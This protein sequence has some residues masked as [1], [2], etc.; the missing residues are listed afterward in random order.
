M[1]NIKRIAKNTSVFFVSQIINYIICFFIIFYSARYLGVEG[2]GILSLALAFTGIFGIFATLGL[3]TLTTREVSRDKSQANHYIFNTLMIR[4]ILSILT[5]LMVFLTVKLFGYSQIVQ[6][7]ILIITISM[8]I[9]SFCEIFN[10]IFQA[11]EKVEYQVYGTILNSLIILIGILLIINYE[12]GIYEIAYTYL[13][14]S[15]FLLL[16]TLLIFSWKF[17]IPKIDLDLNFWKPTIKEALPFGITGITGMIYT[18]TDSL[19]LSLMQGTEVVGWYNAAYRLIL[20]LLFLPNAVNI[21][22]FP[23]MSKLHYKNGK[24]ALKLINEKYFKYMIIIGIPI[25]VGTTLLSEKFILLIYGGDYINSVPIL[26][27]LIWTIVLTFAGAS[28]V[29]ILDSTNKQ[30]ITT[31]ISGICLIVNIALN[32]LLIPKYSYIGASIATIIT[33]GILV[34]SVIYIS[35]KVGYNISSIK[36]LKIVFKVVFASFIMGIFLLYFNSLNLLILLIMAP[37][38]YSITLYLVKG[39]DNEDIK[40]FKTII[41]IDS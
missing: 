28:F 3:T 12:K 11:Y 19:I 13:V 18:Y 7:I 23:L 41:H 16:F 20:I 6:N 17:F 35:S 37:L 9:S 22:I 5:F 24:N 14:A 29:K 15:I 1:I 38:L 36:I 32:L 27:I 33:E 39:I 25:G 40:L 34:G 8:L 21:A 10:S 26:Q 31:K 2:F 4:A 30:M